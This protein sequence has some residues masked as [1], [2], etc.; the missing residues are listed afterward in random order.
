MSY[1]AMQAMAGS[2]SLRARITACAAQEGVLNPGEWV[3][4]HLWK[5]VAQSD[6]A[7]SWQYAVDQSTVNHNPDTGAR[8]DVIGDD[9]ILAT[10]QSLLSDDEPPTT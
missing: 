8:D 1:H 3:N 10:V 7:A 5:I 4:Q 9:K 2:Q 6:W